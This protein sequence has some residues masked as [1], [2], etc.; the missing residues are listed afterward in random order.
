MLDFKFKPTG[1][2]QLPNFFFPTIPE[3]ML[4]HS[5]IWDPL[6]K[7]K[8]LVLSSRKP[9]LDKLALVR[10]R[11]M[12]HPSGHHSPYTKILD[13][14]ILYIRGSQSV[15][16]RPQITPPRDTWGRNDSPDTCKHLLSFFT[17]LTHGANTC[18]GTLL[19][20]LHKPI[21]SSKLQSQLYFS[22]LMHRKKKC[23]I[24]NILDSKS[25]NNEFY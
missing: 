3:V 23:F 25:Y 24:E 19:V 2:D 1:E 14:Y 21:S 12:F 11:S 15:V 6:D 10:S 16:H 13:L 7:A 17:M 9:L 5:S 8:W 20:S 22:R 18:T 4:M